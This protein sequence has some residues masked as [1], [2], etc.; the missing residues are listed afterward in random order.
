[1]K[2]PSRLRRFTEQNPRLVRSVLLSLTFLA[3]FG[4]GVAFASWVLVCNGGRCPPVQILDTYTPRQTSKVYA[5]DGRFIAEVGLE[6]RTLVKI[7]EIP[8]VVRDAFVLTED[9]RFYEHSGIDWVRVPGAALRN[10]RAGSCSGHA[11]GGSTSSRLR[12]R[13]SSS[14]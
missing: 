1:M 13:W 5:A 2:K 4:S 8:K 9:K 12:K 14:R 6:R 3:A 10:L 7:S 11:R